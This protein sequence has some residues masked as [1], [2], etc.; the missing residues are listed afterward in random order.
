L[1]VDLAKPILI[2]IFRFKPNQ[3]VKIEVPLFVA[4][5]PAIDS[6]GSF[7]LH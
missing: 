2:F 3:L 4:F 5:V 7:I 6:F 1:L